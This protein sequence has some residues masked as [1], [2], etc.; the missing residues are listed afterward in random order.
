MIATLLAEVVAVLAWAWIRW[1]G[2]ESIPK[3]ILVLPLVMWATALVTG[4][5]NLLL[6]AIAHRVRLV[7]API[8]II[9]AS[10]IIGIAPILAL[11]FLWN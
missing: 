9:I 3:G 1:V 2:L 5:L 11:L 8:A 10:G 7:R 4:T 6:G